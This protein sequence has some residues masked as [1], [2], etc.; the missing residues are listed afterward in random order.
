M[1]IN[2]KENYTSILPDESTFREF[3]MALSSQMP[4]LEDQH[5][6]IRVSKNLDV[7]E[8]DFFLLLEVAEKQSVNHKSFVVVYPPKIN[9]DIFPEHFNIVPTYAEA[10]DIIKMEAIERDLSF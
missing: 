3:F 6:I 8:K 4:L 1:Y 9:N 7:S 5:L 10:E 2:R